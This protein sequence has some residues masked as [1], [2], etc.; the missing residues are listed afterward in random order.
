M[1]AGKLIRVQTNDEQKPELRIAGK[2]L[3][4]AGI[5]AGDSVAIEVVGYGEIRLRRVD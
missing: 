4:D 1:K 5:R 2:L 3:E